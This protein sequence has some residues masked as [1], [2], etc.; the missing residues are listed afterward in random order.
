MQD[1]FLLPTNYADERGSGNE[2]QT[3]DEGLGVKLKRKTSPMEMH[4]CNTVPDSVQS[5]QQEE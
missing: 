3:P 1:Q 2:K 4:T 5:F